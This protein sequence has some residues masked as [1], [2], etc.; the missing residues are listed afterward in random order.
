MSSPL[1]RHR[2]P[3][4]NNC[5]FTA[6]AHLCQGIDAEIELTV[7]ARKLRLA[8]AEAVLADPDPLTRAVMLGCDSV[9]AYAEWIQNK[10]HWGGEPEVLMLAQHFGVEVA[11][12]SCETLSVLRYGES[13]EAVY[14]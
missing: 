1:K 12:V 7:A 8:C 9:Q 11:V 13:S 14:L 10:N 2:V 3:A 5:L 4:D 6:V